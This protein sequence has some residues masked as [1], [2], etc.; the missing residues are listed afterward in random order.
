METKCGVGLVSTISQNHVI[1]KIFCCFLS[2][3]SYLSGFLSSLKNPNALKVNKV[4]QVFSLKSLGQLLLISGL[5]L[6]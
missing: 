1:L 6:P 2:T 4:E 5:F 3:V